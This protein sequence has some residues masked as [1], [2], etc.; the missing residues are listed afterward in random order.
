[1]DAPLGPQPA[2]GPARLDGDRDALQ[3]GR[4]AFLLVDDLG[5]E[6]MSLCPAQVHPEEHLGPV[7]RL[8]AARAG[9]DREERGAIVVFTA[10]QEGCPLAV[11]VEGE[12]L[13]IAGQ[14]GLELGIGRILEEAGQLVNGDGP[15]LELAPGL[16]LGPQPVGFAKDLL[17]RAPVVPETG[18]E[19]QLIELGESGFLDAEVKDAPRSTGSVPPGPGLPRFPLTA[20]LDIL[21]EDRT[22]LDDPQGGLAPGDDGVHAG[23][24]AVV[25]AD[26]AVAVAIERR[27]V[28][29][30]PAVSLAGDQINERLF[31]G[32]LHGLPLSWAGEGCGAATRRL[33]RTRF[34]ASSGSPAPYPAGLGPVY[35]RKPVSPRGKVRDSCPNGRFVALSGPLA[36]RSQRPPW[37]AAAFCTR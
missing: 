12:L 18:G 21:E 19:G 25:R 5:V 34:R 30:R 15:G 1:V 37:P 3:A 4:L 20:S 27:G 22:E 14:L 2:I 11:E 7:G 6:A 13:G 23:A 26:A 17:G 8:R 16:D 32:L 36:T 33:K 10:E 29:A 24:V 35:R 31:L 9:A 28:T